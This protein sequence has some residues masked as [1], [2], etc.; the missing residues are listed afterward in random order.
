SAR[1]MRYSTKTSAMEEQVSLTSS[2]DAW[3]E[4]FSA[5]LDSRRQRALDLLAAQQQQFS[6]IEADLDAQIAAG[7]A[8]D[9]EARTKLE[10]LAKKLQQQA[11]SLSNQQSQLDADRAD[12]A[13]R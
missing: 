10:Q 3:G 4:E 2:P 11:E 6:R 13:S 9:G 5:A 1:T 8:D 7:L 12:I